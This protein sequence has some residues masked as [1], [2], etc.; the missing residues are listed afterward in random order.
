MFSST[1]NV[2]IHHLKGNQGFF[3]S[4][5]NKRQSGRLWS[6]NII[7]PR[8]TNIFF[9]FWGLQRKTTS[10]PGLP[11]LFNHLPQIFSKQQRQGFRSSQQVPRVSFVLSALE[12]KDWR[13][14]TSPSRGRWVFPLWSPEWGKSTFLWR[15]P[16][17][18]GD[19]PGAT[20]SSRWGQSVF[21][22]APKCQ[23][24]ATTEN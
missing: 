9:R 13:L 21:S 2:V 1:P 15:A 17:S 8:E 23:E 5:L 6:I 11:S 3:F 12:E 20:R 18:L 24:I 16:T 10:T 19:G 14:R 4:T 7:S 22:S